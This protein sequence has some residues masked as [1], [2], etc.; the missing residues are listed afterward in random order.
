MDPQSGNNPTLETGRLL[1]RPLSE[2]DVDAL[3]RISNE[4]LVRHY[5]WDDE[6]VSREDRERRRTERAGVP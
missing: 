1:L 4:P 5:L 2:A 3:R 6:P